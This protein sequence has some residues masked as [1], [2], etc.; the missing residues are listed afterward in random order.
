MRRLFLA[1]ALF[2]SA[3]STHADPLIPNG[4]GTSWEYNLTEAGTGS[5]PVTSTITLRV[6]RQILYGI[7]L[8]KLETLNSDGSSNYELVNVDEESITRLARSGKDGQPIKL[9]PPE[10]IIVTPLAPGTA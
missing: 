10:P 4:V 7:E 2:L 8:I 6:G 5:A 3:V 9:N 1:G